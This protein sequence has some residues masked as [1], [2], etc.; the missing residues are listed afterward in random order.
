M[1]DYFNVGLQ[2]PEIEWMDREGRKL[3]RKLSTIDEFCEQ[4]VLDFIRKSGGPTIL[5]DDER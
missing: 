5:R 3:F 4:V 1:V 2:D